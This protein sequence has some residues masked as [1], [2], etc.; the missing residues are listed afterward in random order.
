MSD[1]QQAE[2]SP[3]SGSRASKIGSRIVVIVIGATVLL[4]LLQAFG[5]ESWRAGNPVFGPEGDYIGPPL[6]DVV[7]PEGDSAVPAET[8]PAAD[9]DAEDVEK[10]PDAEDAEPAKDGTP[11]PACNEPR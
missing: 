11:P 5:P 4:T 8:T 10:L 2:P 9:A 3:D 1:Q 7:P 6:S